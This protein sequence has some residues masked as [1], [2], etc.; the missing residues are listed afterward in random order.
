MEAASKKTFGPCD[1]Y[2]QNEVYVWLSLPKTI[3]GPLNTWMDVME[4]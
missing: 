1:I 2:T 4:E 3:I